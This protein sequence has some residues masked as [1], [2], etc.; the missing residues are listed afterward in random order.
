M[1][2]NSVNTNMGAMVALESLDSTNSQLTSVQKQISTGYKV[3]DATDNGAAF[4]VAQRVRSDVAS[5]T[6][7]NNQLGGTQGLVSTTLS[8]LTDSSN[9]LN[10]MGQVLSQLAD[11]SISSTQRAQYQ[12]QFKTDVTQLKNMFSNATY[13]GKSLIGGVNGGTATNATVV[14]NEAGGTY[15]VASFGQLNTA[16][17]ATT[18]TYASATAFFTSVASLETA[19]ST[20]AQQA[21]T[22]TGVFSDL[23]TAMGT[24]LNYYGSASNY[25]NTTISYNSDKID[26]LNSGL[27]SLVDA[28]LAKESAQL[29][30]LQIKQQLG[31][32][33]LS[34]A[35]QAPQTLL[36]L[37]K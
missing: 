7:V 26:A 8:S 37:F 16:L 11:G 28:D 20:Q 25:I 36:S 30:S 2:L 15:G 5:L 19:N 21:M 14:Q 35:N 33:A 22:A 1:S 27:G 4:A 23:K 29:Q 9:Q 6:T 18:F 10:N 31:E 24:A 3:A 34:I 13:N 32:Q 17:G 12:Q